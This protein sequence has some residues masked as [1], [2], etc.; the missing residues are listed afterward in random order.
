MLLGSLALF[1]SVVALEWASQLDYSLGV[2]YVVPVAVAALVLSRVEVVV[3]AVV[4]AAVRSLFTPGLPPIEFSL[5]FVMATLAYSGIGLLVGEISRHRRIIAATLS[6]LELEQ[7]MRQRAEEQLRDLADSSPAA[8]LVLNAGA[9]VLMA[10]R[11]AH[12]LLGFEP[13][14]LVGVDIS[15]NVPMF[16]GALHVLDGGPLLRTSATGWATRKNGERF[17]VATWFSAYGRGEGRRVAGILVDTSEE[18]RDRERENFRH[19]YANNRLFASA[20]SHEI[21]NL[22][23]AI[24][25]VTS[26]LTRQ[27]DVAGSPDLAA[28]GNLVESLSRLASFELHRRGA[29][30]GPLQIDKVLGQLRLVIEPDW[31][32]LDGEVTWDVPEGLPTVHADEHAL[33]QVLLNLSQ[34]SLRA[35]QDVSTRKLH[36]SA[37]ATGANVCISVEDTGPGVARPETLFQPFRE[38]SA[39]AGLGLFIARNIVRS[40]GGELRHVPTPSGCRFEVTLQVEGMPA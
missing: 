27:H 29:S 38:G 36:V 26:N 16:A 39:G 32:D 31:A 9:E 19:V 12:E 2:L 23:S 28:L 18:V 37:S 6:R 24:R 22:C 20:V 4:A 17:P 33:L 34:N 15:A 1:I 11:A 35:V 14:T 3:A 13:G 21:R 7:A 5:R 30:A 8:I 25:V 40:L 10:N